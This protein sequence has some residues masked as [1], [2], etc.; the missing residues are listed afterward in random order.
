MQE[1]SLQNC[2]CIDSEPYT[3][4]KLPLRTHLIINPSWQLVRA[5]VLVSERPGFNS[6][7]HLF[8]KNV[9]SIT[10]VCLQDAMKLCI[11]SLFITP[12]A[13]LLSPSHDRK[14]TTSVCALSRL[15]HPNW[16]KM[17]VPPLSG[18]S[19]HLQYDLHTNSCR[20][21]CGGRVMKLC[22]YNP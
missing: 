20:I 7:L 22:W 8:W 10:S 11:Q 4:I 1:I 14:S 21:Q 13:W 16:H 18:F 6:T 3:W 17:T 12:S 9:F 19:T 5:L 15:K 2:I